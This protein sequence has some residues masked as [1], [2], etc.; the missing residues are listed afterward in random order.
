MSGASFAPQACLSGPRLCDLGVG[1]SRHICLSV[2]EQV[3][4]TCGGGGPAGLS[5]EVCGTGGQLLHT[6][7]SPATPVY[8]IYTSQLALN[9]VSHFQTVGG[10][11]PQKPQSW[12]LLEVLLS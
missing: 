12:L 2:R 7:L 8:C 11:L 9:G 10:E 5:T 4:H 1:M 6:K 3:E